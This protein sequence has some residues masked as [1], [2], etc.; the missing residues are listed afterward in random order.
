MHISHLHLKSFQFFWSHQTP[1]LWIL[2]NTNPSDSSCSQFQLLHL[3]YSYTHTT[4]GDLGGQGGRIT[5]ERKSMVVCRM[6]NG[7]AS[8]A[9]RYQKH[10]LWRK[11]DDAYVKANQKAAQGVRYVNFKAKVSCSIFLYM[12]NCMWAYTSG[13]YACEYFM[14]SWISMQEFRLL[15]NR[16][17]W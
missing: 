17:G 3:A 2:G 1:I 7:G 6:C 14:P 12:H 13:M 4:D 16:I 11:N 9:T 8:G 10:T 5:R 15:Q